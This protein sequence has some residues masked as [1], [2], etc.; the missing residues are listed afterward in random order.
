MTGIDD[1]DDGFFTLEELLRDD[2]S[3]IDYIG[4]DVLDPAAEIMHAT[5]GLLTLLDKSM[6][7]TRLRFDGGDVI[8][9]R[10]VLKDGG[11][12]VELTDLRGLLSKSHAVMR[13]FQ[14][15]QI[16]KCNGQIRVMIS[17]HGAQSAAYVAE[18]LNAVLNYYTHPLPFEL[19]PQLVATEVEAEVEA[20]IDRATD[21]VA[22]VTQEAV[23]DEPSHPRARADLNPR[24]SYYGH[25]FVE[26]EHTT[27]LTKKCDI[28]A[29]GWTDRY[30]TISDDVMALKELI[31]DVLSRR[32][33]ARDR[34]FPPSTAE[35][36]TWLYKA[37]EGFE[38]ARETM[39]QAICELL[40]QEFNAD[41]GPV[42]STTSN[43]L[44]LLYRIG[45][46]DES[47]GG[48][49]GVLKNMAISGDMDYDE[50]APEDQ[51]VLDIG[52]RFLSALS[53]VQERE[54]DDLRAFWL[55]KI[56]ADASP[57]RVALSVRGL[58]MS[59][60]DPATRC[61][62]IP[63][64]LEKIIARASELRTAS[65]LELGVENSRLFFHGARVG[66]G[67]KPS[68]KDTNVLDNICSLIAA[69][70]YPDKP[71]SKSGALTERPRFGFLDEASGSLF[72]LKNDRVDGGVHRFE[73]VQH[74][75]R[76]NVTHSVG[77][78][79]SNT[80]IELSPDAPDVLSNAL[81]QYFKT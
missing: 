56:A 53:M 30:L 66:R 79:A 71:S 18:L 77:F 47:W 73:F 68:S 74:T 27:A 22:L 8:F 14:L 16:I 69:F 63:A 40:V 32:Y 39:Q 29:L 17:A 60:D 41:G 55:E 20:E 67:V 78:N 35:Y 37:I 21:A 75:A 33:A 2:G 49:R 25:L 19:G 28:G 6:L 10:H 81:S 70:I 57:A 50:I 38:P 34:D 58:L 24:L 36:M 54:K 76:E 23:A 59:M 12:L 61:E 72:L 65:T 26:G 80:S 64:V 52:S 45:E 3:Y 9:E 5:E 48:V 51:D 1:A 46:S 62:A 11:F 15:V 31:S 42:S 4:R 44:E 13:S 7:S 43:L